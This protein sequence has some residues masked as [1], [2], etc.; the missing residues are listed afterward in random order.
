MM[1]ISSPITKRRG[2]SLPFSDYCEPIVANRVLFP[3]MMKEIVDYASNR[4]WKYVEFRGGARFLEKE[5]HFTRYWGHRL[6]LGAGFERVL[7]GLRDST[8]RNI[9]R[10][11]REG[12]KT[13]ILTSLDA[14]G[15]FYRLHCGTRK[16]LGVPPQPWIFFRNIHKHLINTEYGF[17]ILA[18]FEDEIVAGAV[19]FHF[20]RNAIY[21]YGVSRKSYQSL[22]ANNLI[23]WKAIKWYLDNGYK[24]LS[25]GRTDI[26]NEGLRQFK[27][28]WGTDEYPMKYY[29]Y[30]V[31]RC[32]FLSET[33]RRQGTRFTGLLRMMPI[34]V[35]RM[36]GR[37]VYRHIG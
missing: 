34:P 35:L 2:V 37:L 1:E 17:V 22:R 11:E 33:D 20:G 21:K 3:Q 12:V 36:A 16:R 4:G 28:G 25:F 29:R 7:S 32:K 18:T 9:R 14:I 30:D 23:I 8:R 5:N 24:S 10:A 15:Q 26:Q 6:Q 13:E 27:K 19:F 31:E